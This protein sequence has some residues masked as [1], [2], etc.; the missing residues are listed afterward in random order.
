MSFY[1]ITIGQYA[2]LRFSPFNLAS[3]IFQFGW[4]FSSVF[5]CI[6]VL[7]SFER[8]PSCVRKPT[9]FAFSHFQSTAAFSFC[10]FSLPLSLALAQLLDH[11]HFHFLFPIVT[12]RAKKYAVVY[13]SRFKQFG[14]VSIYTFCLTAISLQVISCPFFWLHF[15][16]FLWESW[17]GTFWVLD[18]DLKSFLWLWPFSS[19]VISAETQI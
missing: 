18:F 8:W 12:M 9:T 1:S 14:E 10:L 15:V 17:T 13:P 7:H 4:T 3:F 16:T 5:V 6:S 2:W 19:A 11:F